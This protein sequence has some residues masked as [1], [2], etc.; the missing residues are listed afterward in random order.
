MCLELSYRPMQRYGET[1]DPITYSVYS[2]ISLEPPIFDNL[3]N[4]CKIL[5]MLFTPFFFCTFCLHP[6]V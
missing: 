1:I 5:H 3:S 4:L 6:L 2:R